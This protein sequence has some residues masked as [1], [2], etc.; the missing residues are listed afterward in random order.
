MFECLLYSFVY[1]IYQFGRVG[2]KS[3]LLVH[4]LVLVLKV[5]F[6]SALAEAVMARDVTVNSTKSER[7]PACLAPESLMIFIASRHLS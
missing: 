1:P 2:L 7:V 6:L 3:T 4:V 5:E